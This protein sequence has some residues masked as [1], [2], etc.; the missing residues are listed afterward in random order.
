ML[1]LEVRLASKTLR[2][3]ALML[4]PVTI[5]QMYQSH[6]MIAV[7]ILRKILTVMEIAY[8]RLIVM[9]IAVELLSL[10]SVD[11]ALETVLRKILT[12]MGIVYLILIAMV[13]A[14]EMLSWM[15]AESVKG[16]ALLKI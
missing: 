12:V 16:M 4:M 3:D 11:F 6:A 5:V 9:V 2:L 7:N 14:E 8:L 10:M 13:S 15:N 1:F